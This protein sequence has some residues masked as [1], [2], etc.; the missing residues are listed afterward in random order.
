MIR[1][2]RCS[3]AE[4]QLIDV[5]AELSVS[6]QGSVMF[7]RDELLT[8]CLLATNSLRMQKLREREHLTN[9]RALIPSW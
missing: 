7:G 2:E 9:T 1:K 8:C 6:R 3:A 4:A 5:T